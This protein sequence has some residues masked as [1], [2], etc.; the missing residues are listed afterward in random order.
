MEI[1]E[2]FGNA[3]LI[4]TCT[5]VADEMSVAF[6]IESAPGWDPEVVSSQIR[7]AFH[8]AFLATSA[9]MLA[10]WTFVGSSVTKTQGGEP[11][12]GESGI[13]YSGTGSDPS[14]TVN[15]CLLVRKNTASGGRHNRG[16]MFVPPFNLREGDVN[17]AGV[18]DSARVSDLTATWMSFYD[19]MIADDI[20]PML[21]HTSPADA[22]T[23]IVSFAAQ[24]LCATQR[25]RMR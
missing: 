18:I 11:V 19:K 25:R 17:A 8:E 9:A 1:P 3:R 13:S 16:R 24:P 2:G 23:P 22:P 6:G 14:L 4:W 21:L 20:Q 10:G 15:T 7:I 12:S 5:G